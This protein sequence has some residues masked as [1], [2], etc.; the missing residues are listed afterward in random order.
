MNIRFFPQETVII[1]SKDRH[2][3]DSARLSR[4]PGRIYK[5]YR[6]S[7]RLIYQI[8]RICIYLNQ[9]EALTLDFMRK[10][11]DAAKNGLLFW[12]RK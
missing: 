12:K 8:R 9:S 5:N 10:V 6:D 7:A 3:T 1:K 4:Q 11:Q 2:T